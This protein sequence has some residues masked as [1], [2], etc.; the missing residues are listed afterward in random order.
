MQDQVVW[1][2]LRVVGR[3]VLFQGIFTLSSPS[4]FSTGGRLTTLLRRLLPIGSSSWQEYCKERITDPVC[5][6]ANKLCEGLRATA[7]AVLDAAEVPDET[8][9]RKK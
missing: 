9:Q 8:R 2:C 1:L 3:Q 4:P 6:T 5:V 7:Y